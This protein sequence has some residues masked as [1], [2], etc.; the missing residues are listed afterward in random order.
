MKAAPAFVPN[1]EEFTKKYFEHL[2]KQGEETLRF[3]A[4][5]LDEMAV[6]YSDD[7]TGY[8][9]SVEHFYKNNTDR[10]DSC[11]NLLAA[12]CH[13]DRANVRRKCSESEDQYR[14]FDMQDILAQ[15]LDPN[16]ETFLS[17]ESSFD[18]IPLTI[19]QT[20]RR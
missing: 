8:L 19:S 10:F 14:N 15:L 3:L 18:Q 4:D 1:T 11:K 9:I 16:A 5:T 6:D 2:Q 17:D 13:R 7:V 12:A 20:Q